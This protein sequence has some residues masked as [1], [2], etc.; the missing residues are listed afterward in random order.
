M[1]VFKETRNLITSLIDEDETYKHPSQ[2]TITRILVEVKLREGLVDE[3]S[4]E[5][6]GE[7][8]YHTIDYIGIPF[9]YAQCHSYVH[10]VS[11]CMLKF[12]R[13]VGKR[14]NSKAMYLTQGNPSSL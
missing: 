5:V 6:R 4:L 12:T 10:L 2:H 11:D 8:Y 7:I 9:F 14:K 1:D 13:K 3:I